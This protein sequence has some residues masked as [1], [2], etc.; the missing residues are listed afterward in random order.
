MALNSQVW[1]WSDQHFFH[2]NIIKYTKRPFSLDKA[3]IIKQSEVMLS[4]YRS[5]VQPH[6]LVLFLGDIAFPKKDD[7]PEL[8][9]IF[10]KMTGHKILIKGNHDSASDNFY[11]ELGFAQIY[12]YLICGD[13]FL[14]HYPLQDPPTCKH[15]AA[16]LEA[17]R[18]S[19]CTKII[20]GHTHDKD[21][22]VTDGISRWN[23]CVDY[24][25]NNYSPLLVEDS[26]LAQQL[27]SLVGEDGSNTAEPKG[28][29]CSLLDIIEKD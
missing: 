27:L 28:I 8:M 9:R 24:G 12:P 23:V 4:R 16:A 21:P 6:D 22:K 3:G 14:C 1:V 19:S 5:L 26:A 18:N 2:L 25:Q 15:E 11:Y 7:R 13:Y 29:G 17:F 20:H 10:S